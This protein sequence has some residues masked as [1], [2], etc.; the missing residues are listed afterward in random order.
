MRCGRIAKPLFAFCFFFC[1]RFFGNR[2]YCYYCLEQYPE[3][4][5]D[6][7]R[8]IQLAPDWPKGHFRQGRALMGMKV[9]ENKDFWRR[10]RK[11]G[12]NRSRLCASALQ[13]GGAGHG[14]GAEAGHGLRG[15]R[16]GCREL[17]SAAANGEFIHKRTPLGPLPTDANEHGSIESFQLKNKRVEC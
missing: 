14:A 11:N 8:A 6:A 10:R 15:G 9:S 5:T 7:E 17:Q 4:L 16:P 12:A 1:P 13:R 3:A 2:S